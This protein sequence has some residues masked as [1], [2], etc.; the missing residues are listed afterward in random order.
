[1][2]KVSTGGAENP[3]PTRHGSWRLR[4]VVPSKRPGCDA[5]GSC[6]LV[7]ATEAGE[8]DREAGERL[9]VAGD[10]RGGAFDHGGGDRVVAGSVAASLDTGGGAGVVVEHGGLCPQRGVPRS[11]LPAGYGREHLQ[12]VDIDGESPHGPGRVVA[13]QLEHAVEYRRPAQQ[14]SGELLRVDAELDR[15]AH[16]GRPTAVVAAHAVHHRNG[17]RRTSQVPGDRSSRALPAGA[18]ALPGPDDIVEMAGQRVD[19]QAP[20]DGQVILVAVEREAG[21]R[22]RVSGGTSQ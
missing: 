7:G 15:Q 17:V 8:G 3:L 18:E 2:V 22:L 6:L 4:R 12:V 10:N 19:E 20:G 21:E 11:V 1:M 13:M 5:A 16:P 9:V 14:A